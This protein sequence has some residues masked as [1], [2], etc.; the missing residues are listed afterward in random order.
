MEEVMATT[1]EKTKTQGTQTQTHFENPFTEYFFKPFQDNVAWTN[2]QQTY[3]DIYDIQMKGIQT[4]T[5][6]T[7][8]FGRKINEQVTHNLTETSKLTQETMKYG[9]GLLDGMRQITTDSIDK[10]LNRH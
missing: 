7:M 5:D 8:D 9:M 3:Q 6:Q 10:T 2:L 1:S 4:L